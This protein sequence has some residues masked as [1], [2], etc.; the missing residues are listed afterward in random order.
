MGIWG[1][2]KRV[3]LLRWVY[4]SVAVDRTQV[5]EKVS[6][7]KSGLRQRHGRVVSTC[8]ILVTYTWRNAR[9]IYYLDVGRLNSS[10][11]ETSHLLALLLLISH[12]SLLGQAPK[13]HTK[14]DLPLNI[15][16]TN[17][18]IRTPVR[19][20]VYKNVFLLITHIPDR[21]THTPILKMAFVKEKW[22]ISFTFSIFFI[23]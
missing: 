21:W 13:C 7:S 12:S 17:R 19:E 10:S 14:T 16:S 2:M 1:Q 18:R 9:A 15:H 4:S 11:I 6:E 8:S 23:L 20:M 5:E 22:I 3:E